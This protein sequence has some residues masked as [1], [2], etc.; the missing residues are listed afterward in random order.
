MARRRCTCSHA[1][2][3]RAAMHATSGERSRLS[4]EF[5][6]VFALLVIFAAFIPK[7]YHID[8]AA[9][10]SPLQRNQCATCAIAL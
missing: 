10:P 3:I 4:P 2:L 1:K 5:L 7:R 6:F 9:P 8:S